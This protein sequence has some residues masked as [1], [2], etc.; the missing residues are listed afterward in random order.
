MT[1]PAATG[2]RA[3]RRSKKPPTKVFTFEEMR[4]KKARTD[5]VKMTLEGDDGK[6]IEGII[7]IRAIAST[8]YDDLVAANP[9][10]EEQKLR[11]DSWNIDTFAP[12]LISACVYDP[13]LTYEQA[14]DLYTSDEWSAGELGELFFSCQRVCN[15]GLS[16]SFGEAG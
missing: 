10:T 6:K 1:T 5:V 11:G 3:E 12:A 7:R 15:A 8:A 4:K 2:N 16:V 13:P 9:P 14:C